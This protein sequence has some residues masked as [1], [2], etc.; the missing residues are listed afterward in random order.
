MLCANDWIVRSGVAGMAF[1]VCG[2][3][4]YSFGIVASGNAWMEKEI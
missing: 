3:S 2:L 4:S 1:A